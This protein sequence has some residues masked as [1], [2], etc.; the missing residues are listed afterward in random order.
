ME[1]DP[2]GEH[3]ERF[4]PDGLGT[5][6]PSILPA[7]THDEEYGPQQHYVHYDI[8][9]R[10]Y[11]HLFPHYQSRFLPFAVYSSSL[12][13]SIPGRAP[14]AFLI[15]PYIKNCELTSP[16]VMTVIST[17]PFT[18]NYKLT[19]SWAETSKETPDT[20]FFTQRDE[21]VNHGSFRSVTLVDL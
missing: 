7:F 18:N 10:V 14:K 15:P 21:S 8:Y 16:A 13:I 3:R 5:R 4:A 19:H 1:G 17:V 6:P 20:C 9:N 12:W 11:I 2:S